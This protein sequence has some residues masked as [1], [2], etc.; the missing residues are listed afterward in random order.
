[1]DKMVFW[2]G[3]RMSSDIVILTGVKKKGDYKYACKVAFVDRN[4]VQ[5]VEPNSLVATTCRI[6]LFL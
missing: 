1:M 2:L 3:Y 6:Y 5:F 4:F